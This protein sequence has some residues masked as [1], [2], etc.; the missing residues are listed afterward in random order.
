M[1]VLSV[2]DWSGEERARMAVR[3]SDSVLLGQEQI[4]EQTGVCVTNQRLVLGEVELEG[5]MLWGSLP[6]LREGSTVQLTVIGDMVSSKK[7]IW[8]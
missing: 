8:P 2:V 6:H 1:V 5:S 3:G 7:H 4:C